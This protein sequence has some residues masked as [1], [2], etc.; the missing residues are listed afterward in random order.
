MP[1]VELP[2]ERQQVPAEIL[3]AAR[4]QVRAAASEGEEPAGGDPPEVQPAWLVQEDH[5]VGARQAQVEGA[6]DVV[7]FAY[8]LIPGDGGG[9]RGAELFVDWLD[10]VR[11]PE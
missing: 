2:A 10:P 6:A 9:H 3:L 5:R 1:G 8:P 11:T 4:R 7:A